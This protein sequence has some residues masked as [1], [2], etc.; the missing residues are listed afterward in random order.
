MDDR[1]K[2]EALSQ[3]PLLEHFMLSDVKHVTAVS[4]RGRG[5]LLKSGSIARV[6]RT[7]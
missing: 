1:V 6:R 3:K 5:K 4:D 2:A 7:I